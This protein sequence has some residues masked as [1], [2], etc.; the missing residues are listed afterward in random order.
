MLNALNSTNE[1]HF[2]K[3]IGQL[4]F[5]YSLFKNLLR[6]TFACDFSPSSFKL[7]TGILPLWTK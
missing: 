1:K 5:G 7:R 6:I 4:G 2:P 3:I